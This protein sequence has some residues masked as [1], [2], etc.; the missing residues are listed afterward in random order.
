MGVCFFYFTNYLLF[1]IWERGGV[2]VKD[3]QGSQFRCQN[4]SGVHLPH[5]VAGL[6][7]TPFQFHFPIKSVT[8]PSVKDIRTLLLVSSL[9]VIF[10]C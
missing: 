1:T 5:G 9:L 7:I 2:A 3:A 10:D 6:S 4:L 8:I